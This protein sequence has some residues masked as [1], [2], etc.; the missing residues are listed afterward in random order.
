MHVQYKTCG[1]VLQ[2][3]EAS[4]VVWEKDIL[5]LG[6]PRIL[7]FDIECEKSPLKFPNP[8][9]DRI[10]MVSYM[11]DGQGYLIVNR[12]VVSE[13][14]EDFEY[15]PK[16]KYPGPFRIFNVAT[17]RDLLHKFVTHLQELRPHVVVT[18]N[19]DFFDWPYVDSRCKKYQMSLYY[20]LGIRGTGRPGQ[21][22]RQTDR[23]TD[24]AGADCMLRRMCRQP[25][26]ID[27]D[28]CVMFTML[29][30][31]MYTRLQP[32]QRKS[33]TKGSTSGA[34]WCTWTPSAG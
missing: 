18:Y 27:F 26:T 29:H 33:P 9:V 16:S 25:L 31:V 11:I 1:A 4:T 34:A 13:D 7:A 12:E 2:A 14:I 21:T 22:D 8:E 23:Q 15:T 10:F 24:Q 19:G 6:A 3:S 20:T 30:D 32:K 5:E 17:E 28:F